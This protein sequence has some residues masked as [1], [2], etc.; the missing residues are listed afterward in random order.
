MRFKKLEL[1]G[2]P[3]VELPLR[4]G[5]TVVGA[6]GE[7]ERRR[8]AES[9]AGR[10]R[11]GVVWAFDDEDPSEEEVPIGDFGVLGLAPDMAAAM[12]LRTHDIPAAAAKPFRPE[13]VEPDAAAVEALAAEAEAAK[14][15]AE[16]EARR[17]GLAARRVPTAETAAQ[18]AVARALEELRVTEDYAEA[19]ADDARR[20][21]AEW[22]ELATSLAKPGPSDEALAAVEAARL[23]LAERR[24]ELAAARL[25]VGQGP[26]SPENAAVIGH[27]HTEVTIAQA[28]VDRPF[29][30]PSARRRLAEAEAAEAKFL[31][32]LG[33]SSY[34]A[35]L[36][37]TVVR[38][39]DPEPLRRLST[40]ERAVA[41]AEVAWQSVAPVADEMHVRQSLQRRATRL[42]DAAADL[43]G[44]D[45]ANAVAETLAEWPESCARLVEARA[46][47]HRVL[48]AAGVATDLDPAVT[49]AAWLAA[50]R[51]AEAE[52]AAVEAELAHIEAE[53]AA[54]QRAAAERA[55]QAEAR[56]AAAAQAVAAQAAHDSAGESLDAYLVARLA[57]HRHVGPIGSL[58]LILED[59][60]ADLDPPARLGGL[61][62]LA[63]ASATV[64]VIYVT[65]DPEVLAW[66]AT[67][68]SE[69][70]GVQRPLAIVP[71][72]TP[73]PAALPALPALPAQAAP[74]APSA[75]AP[76]PFVAPA[77][78]PAPPPP[79]AP[80][81]P[82][83]P[84]PP[85]LPA[86]YEPPAPAPA[87]APAPYE[88]PAPACAPTGSPLPAAP[89]EAATPAPR[90][91]ECRHDLAVG[92]CHQCRASFCGDH[93]VRMQRSSRPPLCL[94][95]ALVA[96]GARRGRR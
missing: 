64:Q 2:A 78:A 82:P 95:C 70:V 39:A 48:H 53:L 6:D 85:P 13:P 88:P 68:R 94:S 91:T 83:A 93:L 63:E 73:P 41:E 74:V 77:P 69:Q 3:A 62:L 15:G 45:P 89:A 58:P 14:A 51:A 12:L 22:D 9:L 59:A 66:A 47:L 1:T 37:D 17:A 25:A 19:A 35:Y 67:M 79:P 40:A 26:V 33:F 24:E 42:R 38:P 56:Q 34:S 32:E 11:D 50:R 96:A 86:P 90:C 20:I 23:A 92:D 8:L 80:Y 46:E 87:L 44:F 16:L 36:L 65:T 10:A 52:Q 49:A 57:V 5:M 61:A 7:A 43:L 27:L 18:T 30:G 75:P 60:F 81:E 71:A 76:E 4:R 84:A 72:I 31:Q 21:G 54:L 29:P 55:A 28:R